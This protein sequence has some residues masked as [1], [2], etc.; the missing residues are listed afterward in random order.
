MKLL[1]E[2]KLLNEKKPHEIRL[3]LEIKLKHEIKLLNEKSFY[4][5]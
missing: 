4:M 1:H 2:I 5:K 3:L